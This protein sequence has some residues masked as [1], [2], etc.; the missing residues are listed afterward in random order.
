[1]DSDSETFAETYRWEGLDRLLLDIIPAQIELG[2]VNSKTSLGAL[3]ASQ[4]R[5][6]RRWHHTV[7]GAV[8]V[9]EV[10][11]G[12]PVV[13]EILSHLAG[14]ASGPL[15]NVTSHTG[16]EGVTTDDMVDMTRWVRAGLDNR[17]KT[18]NGQS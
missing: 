3:G 2:I 7:V 4:Q 18:L 14:G 8:G 5:L 15:A 9:L 10:H 1:M 11:S 6:H 16:I 13:G 12:G 17:V